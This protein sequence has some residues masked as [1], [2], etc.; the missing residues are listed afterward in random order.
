MNIAIVG[1][2]S[3]I[4]KN[5]YFHLKNQKYINKIYLIDR[6][7]KK[8]DVKKFICFSDKI[9]IFAGINK[10]KS[11]I[12]YKKNFEIVKKNATNIP[13]YLQLNINLES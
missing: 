7:T 8:K 6:K 4:A 1:S 3:F 12:E 9:F 2:N 10:P 11:K 13:V 5:F